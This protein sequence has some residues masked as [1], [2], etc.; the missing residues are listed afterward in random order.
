VLR[1]GG[2]ALAGQTW[3]PSARSKPGWPATTPYASMST[4]PIDYDGWPLYQQ[5]ELAQE[6]GSSR[7]PSS[8]LT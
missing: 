1:A 7:R 2:G 4:K 3:V 6:R 5:V 8:G